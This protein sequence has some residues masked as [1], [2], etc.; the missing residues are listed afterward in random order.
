[1]EAAGLCRR[2]EVVITP[3]FGEAD[4]THGIENKQNASH[5]HSLLRPVDHMTAI[6][7]NFMLLTLFELGMTS[8][9]MI[10]CTS[11]DL[12]SQGTAT[13]YNECLHASPITI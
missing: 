11:E 1:M 8:P 9:S 13:S 10:P 4:R 12:V 3:Y 6:F 2:Y 5:P 7:C